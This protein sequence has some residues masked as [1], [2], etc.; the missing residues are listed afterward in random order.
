MPADALVRPELVGKQPLYMGHGDKI[1][2]RPFLRLS[3]DWDVDPLSRVQFRG[4]LPRRDTI[5]CYFRV[6]NGLDS[7]E[8]GIFPCVSAFGKAVPL[9]ERLLGVMAI[10]PVLWSMSV[11][12]SR[13]HG[14]DCIFN[15][16]RELSE[17]VSPCYPPNCTR[18]LSEHQGKCTVPSDK[19][20]SDGVRG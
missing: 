3:S 9:E 5:A 15:G 8:D 17:S 2:R 14:R 13:Q 1:N 10:S 12:G 20:E 4:P 19:H 18:Q 11:W 7:T 6:E 16:M